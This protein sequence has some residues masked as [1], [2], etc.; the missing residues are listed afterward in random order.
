MT[1]ILPRPKAH[2][3]A[4]T[5]LNIVAE[6]WGEPAALI[7]GRCRKQPLAFARQVAMALTYTHTHLSSVG[8]AEFYDNRDHS[9]VLWAAKAVA[10]AE[11]CDHEVKELIAGIRGRLTNPL[12]KAS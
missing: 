8:V 1:N 5:I 3:D 2:S 11:E 4:T 10:A 7:I 9:T 6:T 12:L